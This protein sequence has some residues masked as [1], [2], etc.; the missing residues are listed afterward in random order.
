MTPETETIPLWL[1]P[2]YRASRLSCLSPKH[3]Y[4]GAQSADAG[5]EVPQEMGLDSVELILN[6]EAQFKIS[7]PDRV[8]EKL[9]TVGALQGFIVAELNRIG[10]PHDSQAVLLRVQALICEQLRLSPD[11]VTPSARFIEDLGLD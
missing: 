9:Y 8:A 2:I 7:I 11:Q 6:V 3:G 4:A 10:K 1:A 5:H